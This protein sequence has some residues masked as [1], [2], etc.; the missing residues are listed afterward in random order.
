MAISQ[1]SNGHFYDDIKYSTCPHCGG[2]MTS[3]KNEDPKTVAMYPGV[4]S[5]EPPARNRIVAKSRDEV[6]VG[7]Y[8]SRMDSDPVVGWLVGLS[9]SERGRDYRLHTGRNF[10]GRSLKMD[11]SLADDPLVS[12]DNHFSILFDPENVVFYIAPGEGTNTYVNDDL[13]RDPTGVTEGDRIR[14]GDTELVFIA[15]CKGDR[16]WL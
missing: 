16:K 15:Y 10:I 8:T 12:R 7:I 14:A 13:L 11:V 9:G 2:S 6:T 4:I 5:E 3:D 1:C